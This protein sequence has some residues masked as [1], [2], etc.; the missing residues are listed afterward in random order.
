[1]DI[2]QATG[3]HLLTVPSLGERLQAAG[4]K[5][6]VASSGTSGSATLAN[7]KYAGVGVANCELIRPDSLRDR[8]EKVIGPAPAEATPN[9][10]QNRWAV[11][12]FLKV[13]L[14]EMAP[15]ASILWLSDP[16]HTAH[17]AGIGAPKTMEAIKAV[18]GEVGRIVE[19]LKG[20]NTDIFVMSDHGFSTYTGG[21]SI[22]KLLIDAKLKES[23]D[24]QDVVVVEGGIYVKDH[25]P[26]RIG[27]IVRVLQASPKQGA[28]FTRA[29]APGSPIGGVLGTLSL[30]LIHFDHDRAPD[31]LVSEAWTDDKNEFG[32]PGTAANNGTAGHG[33]TSPYELH[34][35][36]IAA[37]PDIRSGAGNDIATGQVDLAPTVCHL[38]GVEPAEGMDG[39]VLK[40]ILKGNEK[41]ARPYIAQSTLNVATPDGSYRL[42]AKMRRVGDTDYLDYARAIR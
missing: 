10:A 26:G 14:P 9:A 12:S 21:E 34:A 11:D 30:E 25:D 29:C 28:I 6:F 38:L 13:A 42:E 23:A 5:L 15:D 24:S 19:A 22:S 8:I 32:Y 41:A 7:H 16:D 35:T 20:R 31:I 3:G 18:D 36:L 27:D 37:G 40:E 17:E 1:M 33:S 39:R 4:K 2:E